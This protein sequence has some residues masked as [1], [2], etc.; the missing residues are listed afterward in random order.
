MFMKYIFVTLG[1]HGG[2]AEIWGFTG[3]LCSRQNLYLRNKAFQK[4]N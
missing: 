2:S 3:Q 1:E 4:L